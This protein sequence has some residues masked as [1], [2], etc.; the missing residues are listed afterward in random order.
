MDRDKGVNMDTKIRKMGEC[1]RAE[2]L[3]M[4]R[5]FYASP[6]V[7]TNGSNEIFN[8][9]FEACISA[10]PLVE[11]FIFAEGDEALGY[12]MISRG[13]STECGRVVIWIED[14]YI[15]DA[16]RGKG[17]GTAFFKF[18]EE[19]YKDCVFKLEV[20]EENERAVAVYKKCGYKQL[21]YFVMLRK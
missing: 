5:V 12:A 20:E 19:N 17:L 10:D 18:L 7:S 8:R 3:G 13:F 15:K 2:V 16:F 9:D 6:A 14:L 4:M 11:G 1:D 21:P